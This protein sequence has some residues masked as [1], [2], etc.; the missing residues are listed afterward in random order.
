M[1]LDMCVKNISNSAK[2]RLIYLEYINFG[3]RQNESI[4]HKNEA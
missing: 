2:Q 3:F 1:S 4:S